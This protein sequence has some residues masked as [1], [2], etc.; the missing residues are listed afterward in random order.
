MESK[1]PDGA[2]EALAQLARDRSALADRFRLPRWYQIGLAALT[3]QHAFVQG[4][5]RNWTAASLA[6]LLVGAALLVFL[7]RRVSGVTV[8]WPPGPDSRARLA[9]QAVIAA[10]LI[11]GSALADNVWFGTSAAAVLFVALVALGPGY[12]A[13]L[14]R[15]LRTEASR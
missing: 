2:A 3:A 11:W 6:A 13:S 15:D 4:V 7:A 14:R 8:A 9:T 5:D 10:V 12:E 1:S